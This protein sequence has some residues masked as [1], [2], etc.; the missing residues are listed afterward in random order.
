[1]TLVLK[2]EYKD[3][4]EHMM[5]HAIEL[6]THTHTYTAWCKVFIKKL[7]GYCTMP[8]STGSRLI[9]SRRDTLWGESAETRTPR[10][11]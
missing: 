1:M 8:Y 5:A 9:A 7:N 4:N 11:A 10:K 6:N 2:G 3:S